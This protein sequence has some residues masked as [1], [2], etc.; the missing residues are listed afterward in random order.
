MTEVDRAD[1]ALQAFTSTE[2]G[3]AAYKS[4]VNASATRYPQYWEEIEGII[5]G[6]EIP[7]K[8]VS[9]CFSFKSKCLHSKERWRD[10][11][12][13]SWQDALT[14]VRAHLTARVQGYKKRE[15][16]E[17]HLLLL[18]RWRF[19][20]ACMMVQ[21]NLLNFRQELSILAEASGKKTGVDDCSDVMVK[22]GD[23]SLA[24]LGHNE[25][26]THDTVNT[27]YFVQ[28]TL[29]LLSCSCCFI[30]FSHTDT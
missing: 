2:E 20:R 14:Q 24:F 30:A 13:L 12:Q 23:P 5:E 16:W 6:S 4:L 27:S 9:T 10:K 18:S 29:V 17:F 3:D 25:D 28:A 19:V 8:L 22:A 15:L 21:I 11:L 26:N 1:S 7:G